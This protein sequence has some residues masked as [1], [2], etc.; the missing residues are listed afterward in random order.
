[1]LENA[2]FIDCH[3]EPSFIG[4]EI[5][6]I[7]ALRKSRFLPSVEMTGV[8]FKANPSKPILFR[9]PSRFKNTPI[10][11]AACLSPFAFA[12]AIPLP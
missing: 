1:M 8:F 3:F 9:Y 6:F 12:A 5:C 10:S 4:G 7:V 2:P 11:L